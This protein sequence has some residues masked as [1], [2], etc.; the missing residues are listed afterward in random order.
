MNIVKTES[1]YL[2]VSE[3][4]I[5]E[6]MILILDGLVKDCNDPTHQK[7]QKKQEINF[8][9]F[10]KWLMRYIVKEMIVND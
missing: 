8:I 1:I 3:A 2:S 4:N 10:W 7:P 6:E 5:F 9:R